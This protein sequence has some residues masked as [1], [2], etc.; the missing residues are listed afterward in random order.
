MTLNLSYSRTHTGLGPGI[1]PLILPAGHVKKM[2]LLN[3][4]PNM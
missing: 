1:S 4:Y 2:N 3:Y